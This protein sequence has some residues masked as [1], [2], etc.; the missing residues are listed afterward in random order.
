M[1]NERKIEIL[2]DV[3]EL[4]KEEVAEFDGICSILDAAEKRYIESLQETYLEPNSDEYDQKMDDIQ[5]D[6]ANINEL[7]QN[8]FMEQEGYYCYRWQNQNEDHPER[9][10]YAGP[11]GGSYHF[12]D[13][14]A[15]IEFLEKIN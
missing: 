5:E 11:S 12:P 10:H 15:R 7:L 14:Q 13:Q 6:F 4:M 1:T 8:R 3:L 2:E 9:F